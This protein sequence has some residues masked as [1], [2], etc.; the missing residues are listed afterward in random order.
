[1]A[2]PPLAIAG[3]IAF[4]TGGASGIGL[5]IASALAREGAR[6]AIADISADWLEEAVTRLGGDTIGICLDVTDR[7]GWAAARAEVEARLG[8]VDI[9][10]NNAGIGPD[11]KSLADTDPAVFDR[12]LAIK[13]GGSFNG[14]HTFVP[15]MRERRRGH[16][17]N[18]ASM[19]GLMTIPNLG[20]YTT[21]KFGLV[22]M[23][24]VLA[25]E[26]AEY[27]VGVSVLCP[28]LFA[29][30]LRETTGR[31]GIVPVAPLQSTGDGEDPARVGDL[32]VDGIRG[33]HLHIITHGDR[34]GPVR[35]RS[36]KVLAAFA[37]ER[38]KRA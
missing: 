11:F 13:L 5:S 28:G 38:A 14:I 29:T 2:H 30:R 6:V 7:A 21:A 19:A 10:V 23:S 17:V 12:L 22:G 18:T 4:V 8:P 15:G 1:M 26:L 36:D 20:P 32:V 35:E 16:V 31:A 33:N 24:E 37:R 27:G 34:D 3:S 9:L 25:T